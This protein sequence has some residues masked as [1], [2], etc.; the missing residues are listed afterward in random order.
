MKFILMIPFGGLPISSPDLGEW[1]HKARRTEEIDVINLNYEFWLHIVSQE[2]MRLLVGDKVNEISMSNT[3]LQRL[4]AEKS[5]ADL[6]SYNTYFS[7]NNY[8]RCIERIENYLRFLNSCQ[9][10]L[11]FSILLGLR[12]N[13]IDYNHTKSVER[14]LDDAPLL[15]KILY[16]YFNKNS[17]KA[18]G[19]LLKVRTQYELVFTIVLCKVIRN[20]K[21]GIKICLVD[22]EYESFILNNVGLDNTLFKNAFD[23]IVLK[24]TERN[25]L[26][27]IEALKANQ[28]IPYIIEEK[29]LHEIEGPSGQYQKKQYKKTEFVPTLKSFVPDYSVSTR[30]SM[31]PCYWKK[32]SF[33]IQNTKVGLLEANIRE[34]EKY[35]HIKLMYESGYRYFVF[36]DEALDRSTIVDFGKWVKEQGLEI[37]WLF[38]TRLDCG[39]DQELVET[40][41][42]SGCISVGFGFET[43]NC[44]TLKSMNKYKDIPS[45]SEIGRLLDMLVKNNIMIH[46]NLI[47]GYPGESIADMNKTIEYVGEL[48]NTSYLYTFTLNRF[49]LFK[50][51]RIYEN[52]EDYGIEISEAETDFSFTKAHE[53]KD[54]TYSDMEFNKFIY[55]A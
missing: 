39:F 44:L 42:A 52:P 29:T 7:K 31:R 28:S 14:Y 33:C 45:L 24:P 17:M 54:R 37:T 20:L 11:S 53:I 19:L 9:A 43:I 30:L 46:L 3:T 34:D 22:R 40:I 10:E 5:F 6:R 15:E 36:I 38:R 13:Q 41:A 48:L 49:T 51:T 26:I 12:V 47:L 35:A 23:S 55:K 27:L 2:C 16:S 50:N 8:S 32:C 21:R 1:Y 18:D 25:L 4:E